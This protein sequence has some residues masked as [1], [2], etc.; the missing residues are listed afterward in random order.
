MNLWE[1]KCCSCNESEREVGS[2]SFGPIIGKEGTHH[3]GGSTLQRYLLQNQKYEK[4]GGRYFTGRYVHMIQLYV[5]Y[6]IIVGV[7]EVEGTIEINYHHADV[8]TSNVS[9]CKRM[10]LWG[11]YALPGNNITPLSILILC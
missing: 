11:T 4:V 1:G 2:N 7:S 8:L 9:L 6:G 3:N 10:V 5:L